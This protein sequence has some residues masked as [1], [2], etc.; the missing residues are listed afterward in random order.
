MT[1]LQGHAD[2]QA[3]ANWREQFVHDDAVSLAA[4]SFT[5][6]G[7]WV[8][9]NFADVFVLVDGATGG[10]Q[11]TLEAAR[12]STF[13]SFFTIKRW[14]IRGAV[15]LRAIVPCLSDQVRLRVATPAGSAVESTVIIGFT[16][17]GQPRAQYINFNNRIIT[18]SVNINGGASNDQILPFIEPGLA[19]FHFNTAAAAGALIPRIDELD[20]SGA[21][22]GPIYI[23]NAATGTIIEQVMLSD[24]TIRARVSNTTGGVLV[25]NFSLIPQG[26]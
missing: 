2:W 22:V 16:N 8:R 20:Q 7:P 15:I 19:V 3:Y 23:N 21:T 9:P 24:H 12:D 11:Y 6:L 17:N 5:L 14:N 13:T 18:G 25:C 26:A 10:A 4:N 1:G